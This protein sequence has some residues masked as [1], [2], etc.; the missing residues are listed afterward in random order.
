MRS[1]ACS[2]RAN[3]TGAFA[4]EEPRSDSCPGARFDVAAV[5][6]LVNP[7]LDEK[8]VSDRV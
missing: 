1:A 6:R 7:P 4:V 2:G 8:L 5:G 3:A